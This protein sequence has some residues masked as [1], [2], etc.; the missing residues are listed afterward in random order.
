MYK[1]DGEDFQLRFS[2]RFDTPDEVF[3]AFAIP[4]SYGDTQVSPLQ[5][6]L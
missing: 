6:D 5:H 3:F 2:H 4:F 1:R